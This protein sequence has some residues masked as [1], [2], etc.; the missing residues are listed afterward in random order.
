MGSSAAE[1]VLQSYLKLRWG[2]QAFVFPHWPVTGCGLAPGKG[3]WGRHLQL[4]AVPREGKLMALT[5][6]HSQQQR[7]W[8]FQPQS[9]TFKQCRTAPTIVYPLRHSENQVGEQ[10]LQDSSGLQFL[11]KLTRRLVRWTA[12]PDSETG[13]QITTDIHHLLSPLF[14]LDSMFREQFCQC[15]WLI[16]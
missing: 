9:G 1:M 4:K 12:D 16:W 8:V 10:L 14:I 2:G 3:T 11:E 5:C 7:E 13:L 6:Q 15:R